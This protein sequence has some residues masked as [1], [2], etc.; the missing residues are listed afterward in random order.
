MPDESLDAY[1]NPVPRTRRGNYDELITKHA[2]RTGL[3]PELVKA[4]VHQESGGNSRA[5]S[6]KGAQGIGQLMPA[7]ARRF[8]VKNPY[9]PDE[10]LRGAT[11][12]LKFLNDRFK[13]NRD[14]VLAGYNAGEG[15]VDKFHGVPPYKETQNYVKSINARLG[16]RQQKPLSDL[17]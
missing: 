7:T 5:V 1:L 16:Q 13:G 6:P 9:D 4:V 8:G 12:Y 17:P 11:D 2:V 15:A 3:D 10:N 14:L